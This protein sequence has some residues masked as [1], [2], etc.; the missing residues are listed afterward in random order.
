M[1][2]ILAKKKEKKLHF[3]FGH[4]LWLSS[5]L[6]KYKCRFP[7]H[8]PVSKLAAFYRFEKIHVQL[9]LQHCKR[10]S[11][12]HSCLSLWPHNI[13]IINFI[14]MQILAPQKK[15]YKKI[16]LL[17]LPPFFQYDLITITAS[18]FATFLKLFFFTTALVLY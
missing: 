16:S 6:W 12:F 10:W 14:W 15:I 17:P 8:I 7:T 1:L 3:L 9:I 13:F 5:R 4:W 2:F 11:T 18:H